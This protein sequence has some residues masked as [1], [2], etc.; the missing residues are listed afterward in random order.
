MYKLSS[1]AITILLSVALSAQTPIDVTD[2]TIKIKGSGEETMLF[3]FAT[4]DRIIFNFE[5]VN[6]KEV[7]EIEI[8]EYPSTARFSDYKTSKVNNKEITVRQQGVYS[9]RFKNSALGGRLCRIH[10][11]RIPASEATKDFNT[12]V[13]WMD[14]QDT[15]WNSFT[16]DVIIGYD[17]TYLQ[18]PVQ[19]VVGTEQ[20]EE[21]IF[22]KSQRVHSETNANSNYTSIFF[23]LPQEKFDNKTKTR[24][25][26]WAYWVGVGEEA[27]QSWQANVKVTQSLISA[28]A[29]MFTSPLG[30]LAIGALT[31]LLT[32]K[33]GED[34]TYAVTDEVN[35]NLFVQG[36]A[37]RYH[38]GGKGVAGY[39]KF[40]DPSL[41]R[42]AYYLCLHNDN[43]AQGIDAQIKVI[44]I[45]EITT[46]QTRQ[47]T[48]M[49][50]TPRYE[51]QIKKEPV[52]RTVNMPIAG[53]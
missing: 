25:I 27:N 38:D 35:R 46:Y 34:V 49:Q 14:K 53:I 36:L 40:T 44:A 1:L 42:G 7:K 12:A 15:V 43:F 33:L 29:K 21:V 10:I 23:T 31:T 20:K 28:G 5:E 26:A 24:V 3:G 8:A 52:I 18:H 39:R 11:Q 4:G 2:Q 37:Y 19:D 32:P 45:L 41:L 30:A 51:K 17:T 48:Q 6:R 13:K 22:D 9:F 16:S 50:V 47:E